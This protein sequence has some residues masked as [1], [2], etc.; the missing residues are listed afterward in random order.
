VV[1]IADKSPA[2]LV[3]ML[4][5]LKAGGAYVP[6]DPDLPFKRVESIIQQTSPMAIIVQERCWDG[7]EQLDRA[8]VLPMISLADSGLQMATSSGVYLSDVE[9]NTTNLSP[10]SSGN[11]VCY[12]LFTS[13]TTG[14]PKGILIEHRNAM[15]FVNSIQH[16]HPLSMESR[17]LFIVNVMFDVRISSLGALNLASVCL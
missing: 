12:V 15:N 13:G 14:L 16:L 10:C 5:I 17:S 8:N 1:F 11:N 7:L 9:K 6:I 3:S 4:A 2:M